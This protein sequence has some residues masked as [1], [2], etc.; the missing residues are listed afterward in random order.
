MRSIST[1]YQPILAPESPKRSSSQGFRN[2]SLYNFYASFSPAFVHDVIKI[3]SLEPGELVVDPWNGSGTT[4]EIAY[5]SKLLSCGFDINPMTLPV[6]R[7][8]LLSAADV[9]ALEQQANDILSLSLLQNPTR[10][11]RDSLNTWFNQPT[12]ERLRSYQRAIH[13]TCKVAT[14]MDAVDLVESLSPSASFFYTAMFRVLKI[15][16]APFTS[17][18]PT[19]VKYPA[20][21]SARLKVRDSEIRKHFL[22]EVTKML[23]VLKD[24]PEPND[25]ILAPIMLVANSNNLPLS[26][27]ACDAVIGSP[28]YCTRIDYAVATS[29][30]LAMLGLDK[31]G[32][33]SLRRTMM[34]A[35]VITKQFLCASPDWGTT[36]NNFLTAVEKHSSV[37]SGTYYLRNLRQYFG[38]LHLSLKEIDR[39][40]KADGHAV[41]V[42]QDS[43]YKDIHNDLPLIV[44]EIGTLLGWSK[45]ARW[46]Y[47][48]TVTKGSINGK[49]ARYRNSA[50]AVESVLIFAK[51]L[52]E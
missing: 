16:L 48:C 33:D 36:C 47:P 8:R 13:E 7:A 43:Y 35:P 41:L 11:S 6:S 14:P 30:E 50:S 10:V 46:D 52:K 40:L 1:I 28:P 27:G 37:A 3:L 20:Q 26:S 12:V 22:S 45:F 31:A 44:E 18:N 19:W 9:S 21:P 51:A 49:R 39:V 32:V 24:Q 5:R 29:P 4:T 25:G 42:V 34:G 15:L 17:T 2:S 38:S 23:A